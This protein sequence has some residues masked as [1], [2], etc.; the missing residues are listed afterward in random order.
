MIASEKQCRELL[1]KLRDAHLSPLISNLS[2]DT[3]YE[4]VV[5]AVDKIEMEYHKQS[6]G[7]AKGR[8]FDEFSKVFGILL[9]R[10]YYV[11][12]TLKTKKNN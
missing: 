5:D 11:F 6:K 8:M 2:P 10:C 12:R 4:S 3:N 7:P 9:F 1:Q